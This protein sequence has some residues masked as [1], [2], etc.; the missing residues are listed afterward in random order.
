MVSQACR[1]RPPEVCRNHRRVPSL[2]NGACRRFREPAVGMDALAPSVPGQE[3]MFA[4]GVE[5]APIPAGC[6][7]LDS[8]RRGGSVYG[9]AERPAER[10][11]AA[12]TSH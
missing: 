2:L 10:W 5:A 4:G 1:A 12:W 9:L 6:S 8:S 3:I 7:S 11:R